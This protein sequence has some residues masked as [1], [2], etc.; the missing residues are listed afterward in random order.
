MRTG[1]RL[2]LITGMSGAGRSTASKAL[3]DVGYSVT[4]NLPADL[5]GEIVARA[6]A[7]ESTRERVAVVVDARSGLEFASLDRTLERLSV[8]GVPVTILFL[9]ADDEVLATRFEETRRPHPVAAPT[10][11]ES[12]AAERKALENLKERADMIV[13]TTDRNVHELRDAIHD[14]FKEQDRPMRVTV[15]SFGFKSGVPRVVDLVF[16]VRFLPNPHWVEE[17]RPKTGLDEA[18]S[19]HVL[20]S[21]DAAGFLRHVEG[22]LDFLVPRYEAEGKSYLTI[23]VGCTG[24]RHRS[25]AI[26][27]AIATW[28]EDR[29]DVDVTVRHRDIDS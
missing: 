29:G 21:A 13:D 10:V 27:E 17:L 26:A 9:D 16:D 25:V 18:V 19:R 3:E 14:A 12:I 23:G 4:D 22:L 5:I 8:D 24:G 7:P 6:L 1:F 11:A 20:E 15:T 2:V 28:L